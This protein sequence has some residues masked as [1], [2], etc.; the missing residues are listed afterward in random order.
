MCFLIGLVIFFFINTKKIA[1]IR[2][3]LCKSVTKPTRSMLANQAKPDSQAQAPNERRYLRGLREYYR[4]ARKK[5]AGRTLARARAGAF[6]R[7]GE[8]GL[9]SQCPVPLRYP[10][11]P[12]LTHAHMRERTRLAAPPAR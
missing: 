2:Q 7:A 6:A 1:P 5:G 9:A 12:V 4:R 10:R 3:T 8:G 11:A